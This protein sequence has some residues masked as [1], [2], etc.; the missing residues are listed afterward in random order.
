MPKTNFTNKQKEEI[1]KEVL[2]KTNKYYEESVQKQEDT[3]L[4]SVLED[5]LN[6]L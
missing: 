3:E 2:K 1:L 4:E 6:N 5:E